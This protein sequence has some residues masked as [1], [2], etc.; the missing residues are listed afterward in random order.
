MDIALSGVPPPEFS[1]KVNGRIAPV[2]TFQV[3]I[4]RSDSCLLK[5]SSGDNC[6]TADLQ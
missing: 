4:T 6:L 1:S 2:G 3:G 5:L